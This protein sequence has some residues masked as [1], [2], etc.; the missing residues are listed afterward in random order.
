MWCVSYIS[1][2][3]KM[4]EFYKYHVNAIMFMKYLKNVFGISSVLSFKE[5]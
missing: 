2:G 4:T 1:D 3:I 5:V